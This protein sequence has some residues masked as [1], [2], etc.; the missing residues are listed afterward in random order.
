MNM[1]EQFADEKKVYICPECGEQLGSLDSV[2]VFEG[3]ESVVGCSICLNI[4][5]AQEWFDESEN[6]AAL[7]SKNYEDDCFAWGNE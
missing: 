7:L 2:F 6:Q 3:S 5:N 1:Y 4:C